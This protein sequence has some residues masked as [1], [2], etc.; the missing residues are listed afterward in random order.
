MK[1]PNFIYRDQLLIIMKTTLLV[2]ISCN[3]TDL[4]DD[5]HFPDIDK[6]SYV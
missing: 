2:C 1:N 4:M 6:C 5:S 3:I